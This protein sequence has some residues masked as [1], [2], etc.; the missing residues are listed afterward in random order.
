MKKRFSVV[1]VVSLCL[2]A[3]LVGTQINNLIS[4][5]NIYEQLNKFKDVL[6]I[7][8]KVYVDDVDTQ[9]LVEAAINGMLGTLD[10]HS[11]YIPPPQ[12]QTVTE[13][14]QGSFEGIGIEFDV[15]DDTILVVSTISG[16][17]SAALGMRAGDR[18]VKINDTSAVGIPRDD[19]PKKLKGP[20]GTH[21]KVS[22]A[23]PGE[24]ELFAFDIVRDKIPI[25][26]VDAAF[27]AKDDIGYIAVN[28]FAQTTHDEF[29]TAAT[30]LKAQGMKRLILDLRNN[31]GGYLDQAEDMVNEFLPGGKTI[32]YTKGRVLQMQDTAHSNGLGQFPDLPLIVLVD[33]GSAS[34][35]EI[36][37]GAIQDWDRGLIVG[38][39][40]FG[41]GLVQRQF[42][43]SD[44]SAFRVTIG[45]YYTPS[46]R[47][48]QRPY[49]KDFAAYQRAAFEKEDEEG[50]N[51]EHAD[52]RDS[53]R[54]VFKTSGGRTVYGGGGITPDFVSN[55]G[56][57]TS[58]TS[59]LFRKNLF[60][61]VTT[62]F[63][64]TNGTQ[65]KGKFGGDA[66]KFSNEYNVSD[67]LVKKLTDSGTKNG[68][69]MKKEDFDKD[70]TYIKA[71]LKAYIARS[72]FGEE[73]W[74][75]ALTDIDTQFQ[76][77]MTL[78]PEAS[79]IA[80]LH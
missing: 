79:K 44:K 47:L 65:M 36:V 61:D 53:T 16:G 6:S 24:K 34:A 20:K 27:M 51:L 5:D 77:A 21:V 75:R 11:V 40:T 49:G 73:G 1:T 14:F 43:L 64:E 25:F 7:T 52:E 18:I 60:L 31:P 55:A 8:Q 80:G 29:M 46:G 4:G 56:K 67:D 66:V 22:I 76:K 17:P 58:Y 13:D 41:K 69:E 45:R 70:Q 71:Y 42:P 9:K 74:R 35:S 33:H 57:F 62:S 68:V 37:S 39:T 15:V 3:L 38:E 48:I 26:T 10:P 78:F 54:P 12:L 23:R 32:V 19:V 50:D 59:A 72:L 28:R 63:M 2:L 30:K